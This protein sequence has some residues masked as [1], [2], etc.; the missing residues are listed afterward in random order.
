MISN[1]SKPQDTITLQLA[2][3]SNPAVRRS[4]AVVIG[5]QYTLSRY[6]TEALPS[7]AWTGQGSISTLSYYSGG[8]SY[9]TVTAVPASQTISNI[10]LWGSNLLLPYANTSAARTWQSVPSN[11]RQLRARSGGLSM[12]IAGTGSS[13]DMNA[14]TGRPM[15]VG[16]VMLVNDG[17]GA[18]TIKHTVTALLG[19]MQVASAGT[20]VSGTYYS[21][22]FQPNTYNPVTTTGTA[23]NFTPVTPPASNIA[24]AT[25]G[26]VPTVTAP[27]IA[28]SALVTGAQSGNYAGDSFIFTV[29][30]YVSVTRVATLSVSKA[31]TGAVLQTGLNTTVTTGGSGS[32]ASTTWTTGTITDGTGN[33]FT[34]SLAL[35][36]TGGATV[37]LA[38]GDT[39]T[40][41]L[42]S[43]YN[44]AGYSLT[45]SNATSYTG[46]G[47][48][49]IFVQVTTAGTTS[50]TG[51]FSIRD[52]N[53]YGTPATLSSYAATTT[54]A[55]LTVNLPGAVYYRTG[56]VFYIDVVA[57]GA[58]TTVFDGVQLDGPAYDTGMLSGTFTLSSVTE[59][60]PYTG[61]IL[62]SNTSAGV[63][64]PVLSNGAWGLTFGT[65]SLPFAAT[66]NP[67]VTP[68]S[69]YGTISAGLYA[70]VPPA[71]SNES[72]IT[73]TSTTDIT[74]NLGAI[75]ESNP[76][77][78]AA[79]M[80]LS[81]NQGQTVY[82][83]RVPTADYNGYTAAL[84]K[85]CN[86][87]SVYALSVT[88]TQNQTIYNA[89]GLHVTTQS[90]PTKKNFRRAYIGIESPGSYIRVGP[91]S[92]GNQAMAKVA[93]Y[94]GASGY[95]LVTFANNQAG[96]ASIN[97]TN[98]GIRAGDIF[99]VTY[100]GVTYSSTVSSVFIPSDGRPATQLLLTATPQTSA[101][102]VLPAAIGAFTNATVYAADTADNQ[103]DYLVNAANALENE[104]VA[105][106]W[107]EGLQIT[108]PN[109]TLVSVATGTVAAEIAG[110]RCAL[111][112]QQ[113]ITGYQLNSATSA[114]P[115][116]TRY[117][118]DQ[119]DRAAA[120]GIMVI[121]QDYPGGPLYIRHQ[122][123][124]DTD[125]GIMYY[126]DSIGVNIDNLGFQVKDAC[127]GFRGL[128]NVTAVTMS[129]I[130]GII[131]NIF[132]TATMAAVGSTAGPQV[133]SF[134]DKDGNKNKVTVK[135]NPNYY[136][137][138]MTFVA[139]DLPAPLNGIDHTIS[140]TLSLDVS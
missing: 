97:L 132:N 110:I 52:T 58:S 18:G 121:C 134:F 59:A 10:S 35:T 106:V 24:A 25:G 99:N 117:T 131:W 33:T 54:Y 138:I 22:A 73:I 40:M 137:R 135:Q 85:I 112:P 38:V 11:S 9:G 101:N 64:T 67:A 76:I 139:V 46:A 1:Y 86:T 6:G 108:G 118:S 15:Q 42:L 4:N 21:N 51:T 94:G 122:L 61:Q 83:L 91:D 12:V 111:L 39:W 75:D 124:T 69:G 49:R 70:L 45:V 96:A 63:F 41:Q 125:Q 127:V 50:A 5:P 102:V 109:D 77:A 123:T 36:G 104:R 130:E 84:L 2:T 107:S 7:Y 3:L 114:A 136:D 119:L 55:G 80:A 115:T 44:H 17:T 79:S 31:S 87:D 32:T 82:A 103:I 81:G 43:T 68:T 120:N 19:Q 37:N 105:L 116:Y 34:A 16:D 89:V 53:G 92:N 23:A 126:E 62:P 30:S 57:A 14:T 66:G 28:W 128:T 140:G 100:L 26:I 72:L 20:T 98:Y 56:D 71:S 8:T 48:T 93:P 29:T 133:I 78:M 74:N 90:T 65:V 47:N 60:V 113:G 27:T 13:G 95:V 129:A 88:G